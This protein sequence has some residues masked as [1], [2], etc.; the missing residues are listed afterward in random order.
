MSSG[1][2]DALKRSVRFLI[3]HFQPTTISMC[4]SIF[5]AST[6]TK[7]RSI[8]AF[9]SASHITWKNVQFWCL[10]QWRNI[11]FISLLAFNLNFLGFLVLQREKWKNIFCCRSFLILVSRLNSTDVDWYS[12]QGDMKKVI[13]KTK[14]RDEE[15]IAETLLWS[16]MEWFTENV[17]KMLELAAETYNFP[18]ISVMWRDIKVVISFE[19]NCAN[20]FRRVENWEFVLV[21]GR[22]LFESMSN[23]NWPA[24]SVE[25]FAVCKRFRCTLHFGLQWKY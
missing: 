1:N 6:S 4:F 24:N 17:M 2:L 7:I 16:R 22:Y 25:I 19:V 5:C 14:E 20:S 21:H 8:L 3:E 9:V 23:E 13:E 18:I 10:C 12:V 15:N 11:T